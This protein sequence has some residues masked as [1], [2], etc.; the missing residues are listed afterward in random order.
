MKYVAPIALVLSLAACGGGTD[1]N[2]TAPAAPVAGA[3]A[4]AGQDWTQVV[5]K[6]AEGFVMGNPNAPIKLVEYGSRL[7]PTCKAF[8]DE[9]YQPLTENY[10]KSGKASFE[11]REFL[12][13]GMQDVPPA[14]LGACVGEAAFFPLM[15]EMFRNQPQFIETLQKS[16]PAA[17]QRIDAAPPAQKFVLLAQAMGLIDFVKQRGLPE[18]K[19]RACLSDMTQIDRLTKI[20]QDR[21]PGGDKTVAGTPTFLI[22]GKVAEGAI[23]WSQVEQALKAAGA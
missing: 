6:T 12:V 2:S 15:E 9:G 8:A 1:A 5:S 4:P 18:D 13:H 23:G 3:A 21:G 11:F 17:L 19:A 16:D 10:V 20:T 22:N 14:A 7:C